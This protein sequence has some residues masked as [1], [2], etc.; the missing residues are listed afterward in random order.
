VYRTQKPKTVRKEV[1]GKRDEFWGGS[2][3]QSAL[4]LR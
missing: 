4:K 3:K 2:G 1:I